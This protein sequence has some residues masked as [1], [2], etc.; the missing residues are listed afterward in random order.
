MFLFNALQNKIKNNV[1]IYYVIS[2][3]EWWINYIKGWI[4]WFCISHAVLSSIMYE[5]L[6]QIC[7]N[8]IHSMCPTTRFVCLATEE[9]WSLSRWKKNLQHTNCTVDA[10]IAWYITS[11]WGKHMNRL[12]NFLENVP[13]DRNWKRRACWNDVTALLLV[14]SPSE[15]NRFGSWF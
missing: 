10:S 4:Q 14:Y 3:S 6:I 15:K 1:N 12:H 13:V 7:I 9:L 2:F 8:W 5:V 11:L